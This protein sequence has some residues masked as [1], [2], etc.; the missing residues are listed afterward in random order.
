[1]KDGVH[2]QKINKKKVP[3]PWMKDGVHKQKDKQKESSKTVDERWRNAN[4]SV[5]G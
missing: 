2:K 1:M 5:T 4:R 3:K